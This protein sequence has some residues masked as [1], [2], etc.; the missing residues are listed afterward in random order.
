MQPPSEC[1]TAGSFIVA[2]GDSKE[3]GVASPRISC[4]SRPIVRPLLG[5]N[6]WEPSSLSGDLV[7]LVG[8]G[9]GP[10]DGVAEP[11]WSDARAVMRS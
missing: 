8:G 4:S 5:M 11:S 1:E 7:R 3:D 10:E 2:A 9:G 6:Q